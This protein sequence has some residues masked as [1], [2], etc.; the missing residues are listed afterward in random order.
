MSFP[1]FVC[2]SAKFAFYFDVFEGLIQKTQIWWLSLEGVTQFRGH[3]SFKIHVY[4]QITL[5]LNL[6]PF[7][8]PFGVRVL[9]TIQTSQPRAILCA[10]SWQTHNQKCPFTVNYRKLWLTTQSNGHTYASQMPEKKF[11]CANN[12]WQ[13]NLNQL[14]IG[15]AH[16]MRRLICAK[17]SI[18]DLSWVVTDY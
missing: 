2:L 17:L 9:W 4:H 6:T 7:L 16:S 8:C 14:W 12:P 13:L 18:T 1:A 5:H 10:K 3:V 11:V 15:L